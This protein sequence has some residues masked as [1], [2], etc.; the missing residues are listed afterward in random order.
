MQD[1]AP[2]V[3]GDD[4]PREANVYVECGT[5]VARCPHRG[6]SSALFTMWRPP[7]RRQRSSLGDPEYRRRKPEYFVRLRVAP[8]GT[9]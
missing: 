7:S 4:R 1:A 3:K 5:A 6:T 8:L 9:P 2:I